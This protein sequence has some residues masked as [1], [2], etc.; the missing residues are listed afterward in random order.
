MTAR[1]QPHN[2]LHFFFYTVM[3]GPVRNRVKSYSCTSTLDRVAKCTYLS[4]FV[5][6]AEPP[7]SCWVPPH[8]SPPVEYHPTPPLLLSTTPPLPS[9]PPPPPP[10]GRNRS[11]C[12]SRSCWL[13]PTLIKSSW[14]NTSPRWYCVMFTLAGNNL[15]IPTSLWILEWTDLPNYS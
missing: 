8:P 7:P 2:F 12:V 3:L 13:E 11:V 1:R 15:A 14:F 6:S 9:P 10:H 5:Q 4:G